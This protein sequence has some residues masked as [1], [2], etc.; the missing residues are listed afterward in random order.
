MS[1]AA[2]RRIE[3][4]VCAGTACVAGGAFKIRE[5]LEKEL[6]KRDLRKEVT[7]EITGCNGF[8]GHGPL[9]VVQPE[10]IF[11]GLIKPE[12]V[13]FLVEEHFIKGKP[14][15]RLMFH[16]PEQKA[17]IPLLADIPFFKK[18]MPIVLQHRGVINPEKIEHYTERNGYSAL[19]KAL[20]GMKP[21]EVVEEIIASGLR[22]RGGAGRANSCL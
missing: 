12:D 7:V 18:Q 5:A 22:G 16:H 6:E 17:P 10:G 11:Y 13:P 2:S 21:E 9:M 1:Q 20:T 8:C 15:E 4:L 14:V 3:M 19:R